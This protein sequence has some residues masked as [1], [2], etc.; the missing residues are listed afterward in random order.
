MSILKLKEKLLDL[1]ALMGWEEYSTKGN[2]SNYSPTHVAFRSTVEL[3][4]FRGHRFH[5]E[6]TENVSEQYYFRHEEIRD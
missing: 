1:L 6:L 5:P 4:V 3:V 2:S